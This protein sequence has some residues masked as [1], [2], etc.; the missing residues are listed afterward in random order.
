VRARVPGENSKHQTI[1]FEAEFKL[2]DQGVVDDLIVDMESRDVDKFLELAL[3]RY[4]GFDVINAEGEVVEDDDE[5]N[6]IIRKKTVFIEALF[7]AYSAGVLN[8]KAKN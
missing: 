1:N 3:V 5:K 7:N 4:W 2:M 6:A 8:Y